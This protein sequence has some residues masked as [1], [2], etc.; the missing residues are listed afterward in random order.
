[1]QRAKG[2]RKFHFLSIR[3]RRIFMDGSF[4]ANAQTSLGYYFA[5]K[6]FERSDKLIVNE[7]INIKL[8]FNLR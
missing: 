1:L 4:V 6:E 5:T 2:E 8:F 7:G 3:L